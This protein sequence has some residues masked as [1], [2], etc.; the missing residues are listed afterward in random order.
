MCTALGHLHSANVLHRD[1]KPSN[2]LVRSVDPLDLV[3]TDFGIS[4]IT[5][6][7]LHLT[8]V[9]RTAAYCAPEALTGVVAKASDWWSVGVIMIELLSGSIPSPA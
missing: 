5:D 8:S 7:S 3:L 4:S 1:I 2:I 9:N 6:L